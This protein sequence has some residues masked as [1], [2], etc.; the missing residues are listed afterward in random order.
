MVL[1]ITIWYVVKQPCSLRQLCTGDAWS[2]IL[3]FFTEVN[4]A[5]IPVWNDNFLRNAVNRYNF[6]ITNDLNQCTTIEIVYY[7]AKQGYPINILKIPVPRMLA[8]NTSE[9]ASIRL[10]ILEFRQLILEGT[11]T[12]RWLIYH[13]KKIYMCVVVCRSLGAYLMGR[14]IPYPL[15]IE[16]A[17]TFHRAPIH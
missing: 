12:S 14:A 3:D 2:I 4:T 6:L 5:F 7:L 15:D 13:F 10:N 9:T 8:W 16:I 1:V 11:K 17:Q